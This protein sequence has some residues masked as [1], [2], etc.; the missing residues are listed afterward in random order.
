MAAQYADRVAAASTRVTPVSIGQ[1]AGV[2]DFARMT[3]RT[4]IA[5]RP[6]FGLL[7]AQQGDSRDWDAVD[8]WTET[9]TDMADLRI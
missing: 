7:G 9:L 4:R 2:L 1:F 3:L 6:I 8:T 5:L